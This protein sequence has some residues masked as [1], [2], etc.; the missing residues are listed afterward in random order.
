[1]KKNK[2]V[3]HHSLI[4]FYN[5]KWEIL[6]QDRTSI[7]KAGERYWF[8]W[9]GVDK[10]ET[11]LEACLRETKEELNLDLQE[12]DIKEAARFTKTVI[13]IGTSKN[14]IYVSPWIDSYE[15]YLQILEG[16]A[17]VWMTLKEAKKEVFFNHDYMVF[18]LLER[19]FKHEWINI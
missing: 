7:S 5:K 16:D 9:G 14:V 13:W 15:K 8:F 17:G 4:A 10:G 11:F 1:M 19:Y 2:F 12:W 6:F 18:D 3:R